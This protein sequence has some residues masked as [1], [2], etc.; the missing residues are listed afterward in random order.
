[1]EL[2][3][4]QAK[5]AQELA[6]AQRISTSEI[7]EIEEFYDVSGEGNLGAKVDESAFSLGAAGKGKKVTKR[8]IKFS[9]GSLAQVVPVE[10]A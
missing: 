9:G 7:V 5:V 2:Q 6:I 4:H 10:K 1:M 3:S 8:V